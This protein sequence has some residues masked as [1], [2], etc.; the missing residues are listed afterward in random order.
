MPETDKRE[1]GEELTNGPSDMPVFDPARNEANVE[2][3]APA[4]A[5]EQP[6][7]TGREGQHAGI[8]AEEAD[9]TGGQSIDEFADSVVLGLEHASLAME[10]AGPLESSLGLEQMTEAFFAGWGSPDTAEA[11]DSPSEADPVNLEALTSVSLASIASAPHSLASAS[12]AFFSENWSRLEETAPLEQASAGLDELSG[13]SMVSWSASEGMVPD[14]SAAKIE[15]QPVNLGALSEMGMASWGASEGVFEE[16]APVLLPQPES[17]AGPLISGS[18]PLAGIGHTSAAPYSTYTAAPYAAAPADGMG[19]HDELAHDELADAVQ[20]ALRSIYGERVAR[21]VEKTFQKAAMAEEK[22]SSL[23]WNKGASPASD[24]LTPQDV[25]ASYF[26]YTP[27]E[28]ESKAQPPRFA[29]PREKALPSQ[30]ARPSYFDYPNS[31]DGNGPGQAEYGMAAAGERE[32]PINLR[33]APEPEVASRRPRAPQERPARWQEWPAQAAQPQQQAAQPPQ[34]GG[35]ASFPVPAGPAPA[36]RPS[37]GAASQ[38]S[39]RL[40]GAAAIGLMGGIAIAA[41]LAA[42]LIYGPHPATVEIPG[43]G[44]LR[45]D[46]DEQGYGRIQEDIF[47]EPARSAAPRAQSEQSSEIVAADAVAVPGQPAPLAI[48]VRS[49]R[50]FDKMLV[51]ISGVPEG[52]RLSAG[53]DTGG[54]NWVVPPRR[55]NGLAINLP[56]DSREPIQLGAQLLDSNARTPLS[57]KGTFA[58]HVLPATATASV[59][60]KTADASQAAPAFAPKQSQQSAA[61]FPFNIQALT[62]PASPPAG[63]QSAAPDAS[64]RTQTVPESTSQRQAALPQVTA[65]PQ[66]QPAPSAAANAFRRAIPQ[67]E[68]QDLIREGNKRMREGDILEA[69]QFYQRAVAFGGPD[70]A[71]AMGRSYDPIYFARIDKKNAEPDAAKAFDWYKK[72]LDA[73]AAQTAMVRIENLKHFLNE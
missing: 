72:A 41:S 21:P 4:E 70:A 38:E 43:I 33:A 22:P 69:R 17:V 23:I 37:A 18:Q 26:D 27:E 12:P 30:A 32:E 36:S 28:Q 1:E 3:G 68:V 10:P 45:L 54:G 60:A 55:L 58:I 19:K 73:G 59:A 48:S 66:P 57:A 64:F 25:I 61:G 40:L 62:P 53:V 6:A 67:P 71:L 14:E 63:A 11:E 52:A 51:A 34:Y 7:P 47:K 56:A 13:M 9:V 24:N 8:A 65:V 2:T 49:E 39:S 16:P 20:S 5:A 50:P 35:P 44:N 15:P 31:Q 29:A 42:F 46:K